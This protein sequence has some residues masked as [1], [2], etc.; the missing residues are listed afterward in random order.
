MVFEI[1]F[2]LFFLCLSLLGDYCEKWDP[3]V[4]HQCLNGG[5]CKEIKTERYYTCLCSNNYHGKYCE[6]EYNPC[7]QSKCVGNTQCKV[8]DNKATCVTKNIEITRTRSTTLSDTTT[9]KSKSSTIKVMKKE[10]IQLEKETVRLVQ[11][12][13]FR[14]IPLDFISGFDGDSIFLEWIH[15]AGYHYGPSRVHVGQFWCSLLDS[16]DQIFPEKVSV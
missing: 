3:C 5:Y 1:Y 11:Y 12:H 16:Q 15:D 8:V 4:K 6:L 10:N 14:V 13:P 9:N 2:N 7:F